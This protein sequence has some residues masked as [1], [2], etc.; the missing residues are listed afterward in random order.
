MPARDRGGEDQG[1]GGGVY[2]VF[3]FGKFNVMKGLRT[4]RFLANGENLILLGPPEVGKMYMTIGLGID[5][6][7]AGHS[8]YHLNSVSMIAKLRSAAQRGTL[9]QALKNLCRRGCSSW[10][11]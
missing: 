1:K 9:E 5:T 4:L 8:A 7:R 2:P 6:I 10:T 11:R 3:R